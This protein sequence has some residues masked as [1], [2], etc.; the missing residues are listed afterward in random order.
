MALPTWAIADALAARIIDEIG[1][2]I[3]PTGALG[4]LQAISV[5]LDRFRLE[6]SPRRFFAEP[7]RG[8]KTATGSHLSVESEP[9][10]RIDRTRVRSSP[11]LRDGAWSPCFGDVADH[12]KRCS[13][14]LGVWRYGWA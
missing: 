6:L 2:L 5:A 13:A 12:V 14:A 3:A 8:P 7:L 10:C 11:S 4:V 9:L 1:A